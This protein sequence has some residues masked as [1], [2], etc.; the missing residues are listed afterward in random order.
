MIVEIL[1][2][3]TMEL[4]AVTVGTDDLKLIFLFPILASRS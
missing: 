1:V 3:T 2:I 4:G